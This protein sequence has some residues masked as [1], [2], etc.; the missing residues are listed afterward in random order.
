M[1]PS[2]P[3]RLSF[4]RRAYRMVNVRGPCAA[5]GRVLTPSGS[6]LIEQPLSAR[7]ARLLSVIPAGIGIGAWAA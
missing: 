1:C 3:R 5:A 2:M 7:A 4:C 6:N